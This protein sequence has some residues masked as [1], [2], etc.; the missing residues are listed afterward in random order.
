MRTNSEYEI[1]VNL[2]NE[3]G[4]QVSAPTLIKSL[5]RQISYIQIDP[6]D[7]NG[8]SLANGAKKEV[9]S[10]P[11]PPT[12]PPTNSNVNSNNQA[13]TQPANDP[14]CIDMN[15]SSMVNKDGIMIRKSK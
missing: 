15:N 6:I 3:N 7:E 13:E 11:P 5:K 12:P 10:P 8:V 9:S 2:E 14:K 1:F 4:D